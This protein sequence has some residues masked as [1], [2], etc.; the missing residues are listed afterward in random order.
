[1]HLRAIL[2]NVRHIIHKNH[3]LVLCCRLTTQVHETRE[4]VYLSKVEVPVA[5]QNVNIAVIN[6]ND[7][8]LRNAMSK[9]MV[10]NLLEILNN[11]RLD[12]IE[13]DQIRALIVRSNV[14]GVFCAGADLKERQF[15]TDLQVESWLKVQRNLMDTI[16]GF[17]Y[18]TIAAIDGHAIGGGLELA[19]ACDLRIVNERA[20]VGLVETSWAI[21][22]G[23]GGTQRLP[24]L[25]G[26]GAAK[27]HIFVG[28]PVSGEEAM[29]LGICN[30]LVSG[31]E[32]SFYKAIE[33][34]KKICKR[35]PKALRLAK[36]AMD[37]GT[38]T[39]L[40][41]G[42]DIE[43]AHYRPVIGT[44]DRKEGMKAFAEKRSPVY[45]GN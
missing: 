44:S 33:I 10:L 45:T 24:R 16:S 20:K 41:T 35:G 9:K 28:E 2:S 19:L 18:P 7:G 39:S 37:I 4:P 14:P 27:E 34:A 40:N 17:P 21:I 29:K 5:S 25:I 31:D 42:L 8:A 32:A 36:A 43:Y 13:N 23:A 6:L 30:H 26:I 15:M 12:Q 22:P 38:Q 1:M 3:H 11:L